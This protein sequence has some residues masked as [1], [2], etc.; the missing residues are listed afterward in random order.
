MSALVLG[1]DGCR[2]RWLGFAWHENGASA[3]HMFS[4]AAEV[5]GFPAAAVAVDI[6]IGLPTGARRA[7]DREASRLLSPGKAS[8][9]VFPTPPRSVR[10]AA[11]YVEACD[12]SFAEIG[13]KLSK[14]SWGLWPKIVDFD[15]A[16]VDHERLVEAHPELS[17]LRMA[18]QV[19]TTKHAEEGLDERIAV[20]RRHMDVVDDALRSRPPKAA[21][22]DC[23]DAMACAWT[24]RRW[25][26]GE[27][28]VLGHETDELGTPM[29]IVV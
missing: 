12:I 20:L 21:L 22:D 14:Q 25:L 23:L 24:A 19:L 1:V 7:C 18:G 2:D 29:R 4:D 13:K 26:T 9:R 17:F 10:Q 16:G 11:T 3:W 6:P 28:E 8:S 27:A 5:C 15:D